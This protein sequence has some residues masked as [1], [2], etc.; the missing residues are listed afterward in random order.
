MPPTPQAQAAQLIPTVG[1]V[2]AD[3]GHTV[4][5]LKTLADDAE[6]D[7]GLGMRAVSLRELRA[8]AHRYGQ[9]TCRPAAIG[10]CA[11]G[12]R[13]PQGDGQCAGRR[14]HR[15]AREALAAASA[16]RRLS[17]DVS[18]NPNSSQSAGS[19]GEGREGAPRGRTTGWGSA[20]RKLLLDALCSSRAQW[21]R[22]RTCLSASCRTSG[23]SSSCAARATLP[24]YAAGIVGKSKVPEAGSQHHAV[25]GRRC[26]ALVHQPDAKARAASCSA[27]QGR[28]RQSPAG[29]QL[30]DR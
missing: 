11:C 14:R 23:R 13:R 8:G 20:E 1:A 5:R 26:T 25:E 16:R 24:P 17:C 12:G 28:H 30:P 29:C 21:L 15:R 4:E 7:G 19:W 3:L 10:T 18:A 27:G 22:A 9:I 6:H 2:L